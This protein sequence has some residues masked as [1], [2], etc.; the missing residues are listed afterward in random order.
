MEVVHTKQQSGS[1]Q[2]SEEFF[3]HKTLGFIPPHEG[4]Q[5][6]LRSAVSHAIH[7]SMPVTSQTPVSGHQT[8][9]EEAVSE[10]AGDAT[11]H[12]MQKIPLQG[13][14]A[15]CPV[16]QGPSPPL[17]H[18]LQ[19]SLSP[20]S[21]IPP[22]LVHCRDSYCGTGEGTEGRAGSPPLE[23]GWRW[24]RVWLSWAWAGEVAGEG[25]RPGRPRGR[26]SKGCLL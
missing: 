17:W 25:K 22:E 1:R 4:D 7:T 20:P 10:W 26:C 6:Q 15:W 12:T 11:P 2:Q 23:A 5:P 24:G 19:L 14:L 21:A 3:L 13:R 16:L 9:T 18:P 8:T